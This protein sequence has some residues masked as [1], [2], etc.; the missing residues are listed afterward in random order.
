MQGNRAVHQST[1]DVSNGVLTI[2]LKVDDCMM[3]SQWFE[4]M[5][6]VRERAKELGM[7]PRGSRTSF[8]TAAKA[9]YLQ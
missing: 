4:L 1:H 5:N 2:E 9:E 8:T 6:V 7:G 3:P